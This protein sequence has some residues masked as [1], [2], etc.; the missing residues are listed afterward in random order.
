MSGPPETLTLTN[1]ATVKQWN[2]DDPELQEVLDDAKAIEKLS[3][4]QP[5]LTTEIMTAYVIAR[6]PFP[7]KK[8]SYVGSGAW[9]PGLS[10]AST[11]AGPGASPSSAPPPYDHDLA[12]IKL[13]IWLKN[14]NRRWPAKSTTKPDRRA[15][16]ELAKRFINDVLEDREAL[17]DDTVGQV[18]AYFGRWASARWKPKPM[19]PN[20]PVIVYHS[21][22]LQSCILL[23]AETIEHL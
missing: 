15:E 21:R 2:P 20:I 10:R 5:Y 16:D 11:A 7:K 1:W 14:E 8:S 4:G 3:E 18:S 22:R 13:E 6:D 12:L 23:D 9:L 17:A 19:P